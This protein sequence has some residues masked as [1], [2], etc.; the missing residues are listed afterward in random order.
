MIEPE[1]PTLGAVLAVVNEARTVRENMEALGAAGL[2]PDGWAT[3]TRRAWVCWACVNGVPLE[4]LDDP[5]HRLP[6]ERAYG[7]GAVALRPDRCDVCDG[8][9][10]RVLPPAV[11]SLV[12]WAS[13]GVEGIARVEALARAA[14][15]SLRAVGCPQ[16]D[17]VLW[18]VGNGKPIREDKGG[19]F[20]Y[21]SNPLMFVFAGD[22]PATAER[23]GRVET[24]T[25]L[26]ASGHALYRATPDGIT[27]VTPRV[28]RDLETSGASRVR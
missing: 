24:A 23:F 15:V 1:R 2:L 12:A 11:G 6:G 18:K 4:A 7:P 14:V 17:R 26:R 10:A 9:G 3:D 5:P 28:P 25:A 21:Q 20:R 16:T 27:L 8:K 19:V 13:L 22:G